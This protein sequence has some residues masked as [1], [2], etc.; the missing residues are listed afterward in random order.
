MTEKNTNK[1]NMSY[2]EKCFFWGE[3]QIMQRNIAHIL[4][5]A[6]FKQ[7][8]ETKIIDMGRNGERTKEERQ[9]VPTQFE[10]KGCQ[11]H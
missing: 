5:I 3:K 6:K 2:R 11:L 4:A 1:L 8:Q 9:R 7:R 10:R